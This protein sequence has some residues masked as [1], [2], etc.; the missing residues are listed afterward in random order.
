MRIRHIAPPAAFPYACTTAYGCDAYGI[1]QTVVVHGEAQTFRWCPPGSFTMGSPVTEHDHHEDEIQREIVLTK[2]FWL[3]DTACNQALWTAVMGENPSQF[4]GETLPVERV[5]FGQCEAFLE[6]WR[7]LCPDFPL[8]FPS[9]AEWEYACRA[10]MPTPFSFGETI[11]SNQVNFDGDFPYLSRDPKGEDRGSTVA[12]KALPCNAWGLYQMHGNVW[13][14]CGDWYDAYDPSDL[15]DPG[16][17]L[18][19]SMHV[20]RGGSFNDYARNCRSAYRYA[21]GPGFSWQRRGFRAAGG[22]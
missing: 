12:V 14:W 3:A 21:F 6:R 10:G 16:G 4:K 11:S 15:V 13:E 9:E 22:S 5:S 20:V 8:R 2:G 18:Q 19:G 17:P 1:W 7:R